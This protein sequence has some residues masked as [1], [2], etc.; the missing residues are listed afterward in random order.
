MKAPTVTD[1]GI[2]DVFRWLLGGTASLFVLFQAYDQGQN[3]AGV[4][5]VDYIEAGQPESAAQRDSGIVLYLT[6]LF[7]VAIPAGLWALLALWKPQRALTYAARFSIWPSVCISYLLARP[8]VWQAMAVTPM[9]GTGLPSILEGSVLIVLVL[10][11][12]WFVL[13]LLLWPR[14]G[15][16]ASATIQADINAHGV[17]DEQTSTPSTPTPSGTWNPTGAAAGGMAFGIIGLVGWCIPVLGAMAGVAGIALATVGMK[18]SRRTMAL[19]GLMLSIASL[20][21]SL[22][23]GVVGAYI[24]AAS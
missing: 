4:A 5:Y 10:G 8:L 18:S 20:I 14:A 11:A 21:L 3:G 23:N 1:H 17:S 16:S 19:V 22:I 12:V 24:G 6:T 13:G 9:P 15:R 2:R 7:A